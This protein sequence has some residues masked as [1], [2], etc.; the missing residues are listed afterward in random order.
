[1]GQQF[2]FPQNNT[3][4]AAARSGATLYPINK[5]NN[6]STSW[7]LLSN[8]IL[9]SW[10][11]RLPYWV[12]E[13][14]RFWKHS[15]SK[16]HHPHPNATRGLSS[17]FTPTRIVMRDLSV[18]LNNSNTVHLLCHTICTTYSCWT[19]KQWRTPNGMLKILWNHKVHLFMRVRS[20]GGGRGYSNGSFLWQL[21]LDTRESS[22]N[23]RV[24]PGLRTF[25]RAKQ[26][27]Q[28][29]P[30]MLR[31]ERGGRDWLR[32]SMVLWWLIS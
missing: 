3:P 13:M 1:M 8:T 17:T 30:R 9:R 28:D 15:L 16:P 12:L 14:T 25:G 6:L 2:A 20:R 21:R 29:P 10:S 27:S 31:M 24:S 11:C 32:V 22:W 23:L 26:K 18:V 5:V 7:V 19:S 4:A